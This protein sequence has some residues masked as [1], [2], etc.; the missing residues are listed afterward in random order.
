[1]SSSS[2]TS[3]I[4]RKIER[5]CVMRKSRFLE[6]VGI[7]AIVGITAQL[8]A[9]APGG[10]WAA[11]PSPENEVKSLYWELFSQTETWIRIVPRD[12]AGPLPVSVVFSAIRSAKGDSSAPGVIHIFALPSPIASL[13]IPANSLRFTNE[14]GITFDLVDGRH[15]EP[16]GGACDACSNQGIAATM[17]ISEFAV[18]ASSKTLD[19]DVFG[20]R[21]SVSQQGLQGL[22]E[23][24]KR[25]G[26]S[27]PA[28]K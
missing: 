3:S 20:F 10:G 9:Q 28:L 23:L 13:P 18:L 5:E 2:I 24:I 25:A 17:S 19:C 6:A 15:V 16:L 12:P 8:F 14:S 11:L 22:R 1:M 26:L 4:R 21:C 7:A 27:V